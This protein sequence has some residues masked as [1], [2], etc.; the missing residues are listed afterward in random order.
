MNQELHFTPSPRTRLLLRLLAGVGVLSLLAGAALAPERAWGSLFMASYALVC[1]GLSGTFFIALTYACGAS[2]AVA[3]R[4]IPEA[5]SA[6]MPFGAVGVAAVLLFRPSLYPWTH[7]AAAHELSGFKA[8]WLNWPFFLARAAVYFA[9][10]LL[11]TRL[12]VRTS[13]AQDRDGDPAHTFRNTKLSVAFLPL[14]AVTFS[15]AS[16]DW[17][18]SLEP[19]WYSTIFGVYTFSGLFS[20][21]LAVII[22]LAIWMRRTG[23][24][25]DFV[26]EE[27]LHDLGKLLFAFATFWMYI[28]FS[29]YMLIWYANMT[30]ET[31]HFI[32]RQRSF[33]LPL[34][35]LNV[36]LN[37]GIP[38]LALLP[39]FTKRTP[40]TL[41]KVAAVV[42]AG[43]WLDLYMMVQPTVTAGAITFP[44]I[45]LG[46]MAGA[47]ALVVVVF[48]RAFRQAP[49]TPV[50]DPYLTE[51]LHYHN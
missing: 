44:W 41:A 14:F 45:E 4:R 8:A 17:I 16:V 42:I 3:L 31:V 33:W 38:F 12:I 22:L 15:M 34:L 26:T 5:M 24:L 51:S 40:S 28:W 2:W 25:R 35:V 27:H 43:R 36:I 21:G 19:E 49:E 39:K 23:P 48:L 18:M 50:R 10:W 13:R 6:V 7:E 46:V 29:Q 1:L 20:S 9:V 47:G 30:E 11:F 32:A 37:W